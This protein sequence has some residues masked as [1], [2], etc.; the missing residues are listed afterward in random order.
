M[1]TGINLRKPG[2]RWMLG[3][4][5]FVLLGIGA[6]GQAL[7]RDYEV[8]ITDQGNTK[9]I[10]AAA[11]TGTHGGMLRVYSSEDLQAK[12]PV[13]NPLNIDIADL[14]PNALA[15]TG[16]DVIRLHGALPSPD[17][18]YMAAALVASGHV[19]IIDG[20][21]KTAKA[22]FR[23]TG[24]ATGRQNHM[25]FWTANGKHL[26]IAN[27]AGRLLERIDYN[28]ATD[29]FTFNAAATLDLVG[30]RAMTAAPVADPSLPGGVVSGAVVNGQATTTPNGIAKQAA[31][32]RPN[33]SVICPIISNDNVHAYVSLA[34]G[35]MFVVDITTT[36]MSIVAEYDASTVPA[37]GCGGMQEG[38]FVFMNQGTSLVA[39]TLS[40]FTVLRF[41]VNYPMA[42]AFNA[43][44]S[45]APTL[46]Y[47]DP[48]DGLAVVPPRDAHGMGMTQDARAFRFLHQFDRV[49]NNVE[50][51]NTHTLGRVNTYYLTTANG[52]MNGDSGT[53][54]GTTTGATTSNDPTP[55]LLDLSP[56]GNRFY[57][58]LRGPFPLTI[59]HAAAGSCPGLGIVQLRKGGRH[60]VL[61]YVL[62]TTLMSF[63]GLKNMS[64][65]HGS[66]V[67]L[68]KE[69]DDEG[70]DELD[71]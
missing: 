60:G 29:T 24:T 13:D 34:G 17:H 18:R 55:D 54:C 70:D 25:G 3:K 6:A 65:P 26:L 14:F 67:R 57:V 38:R 1:N 66:A 8:W 15:G 40:R 50:V 32:I 52:K 56:N 20:E 37:A 59:A 22:L 9:G 7:A 11:N 47:S 27:Q 46:V 33:N 10:S 44:N 49:R 48:D 30:G 42:P 36:P 58:A 62:P 4:I 45:P 39:P 28:A 43:P 5:A 16:A 12:P 19:A 41:P 23:T 53:A 61:K 31:G 71:D 2:S 64:D 51:F 68:V 69:D 21:T 63:D 35:G